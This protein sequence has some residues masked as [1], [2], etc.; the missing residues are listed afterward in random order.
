M[1][2]QPT[3]AER[4]LRKQSPFYGEME[5]NIYAMKVNPPVNNP[6]AETDRFTFFVIFT[7]VGV[8]DSGKNSIKDVHI[9][10]RF[11]KDPQS[12]PD[13]EIVDLHPTGESREVGTFRS[14]VTS[15]GGHIIGAGA[16][17]E[18]TVSGLAFPQISG[19]VG[20]NVGGSISKGHMSSEVVTIEYPNFIN[21]SSSM[22]VGNHAIWEFKQGGVAQWTGQYNLQVIFKINAPLNE[23][24]AG[25]GPYRINWNIKI[26]G[27]RLI[28]NV[29]EPNPVPID[30]LI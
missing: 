21:I 2:P 12:A 28:W 15:G 23:I 3:R 16:K 24:K 30:F 18:A 13:I 8:G 4:L 19:N 26:N 1:R 6:F 14:K 20:G 27:R 5:H 29:S 10:F 9:R 22:G 17:A 7:K 11:E 25:I